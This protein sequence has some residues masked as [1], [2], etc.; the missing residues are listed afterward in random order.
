[1]ILCRVH[2]KEYLVGE[3]NRHRIDPADAMTSVELLVIYMRHQEQHPQKRRN[4]NEQQYT[5]RL[6]QVSTLA[7]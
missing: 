2:Y 3:I 4:E 5:D 7:D 6:R 1:M